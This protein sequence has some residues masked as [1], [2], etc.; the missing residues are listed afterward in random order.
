V[1]TFQRPVHPK[2]GSNDYIPAAIIIKAAINC[3]DVRDVF[4]D[5]ADDKI[6]LYFY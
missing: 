1:L 2:Q 4:F 6:F 5:L 3:G